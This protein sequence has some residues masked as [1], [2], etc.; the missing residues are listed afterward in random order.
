MSAIITLKRRVG[1][2]ESSC[3]YPSSHPC[4]PTTPNSPSTTFACFAF[5]FPHRVCPDYFISFTRRVISFA[6]LNVPPVGFPHVAHAFSFALC[7][8]AQCSQK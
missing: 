4:E 7:L 2:T 1:T 3:T 5:F 6:V 8:S